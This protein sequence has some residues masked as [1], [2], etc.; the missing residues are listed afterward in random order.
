MKYYRD[1][2]KSMQGDKLERYGAPAKR[3]Y[4]GRLKEFISD[5]VA[6]GLPVV[7][8]TM[9]SGI[10]RLRG[11]SE[12]EQKIKDI[13]IDGA[14]GAGAGMMGRAASFGSRRP[15]EGEEDR[16]SGGRIQKGK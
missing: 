12:E 16:A 6:P 9:A 5:Y 13:A 8:E 10:K 3:E 1:K 15:V 14:A 11:P 2:A 4:G 7:G